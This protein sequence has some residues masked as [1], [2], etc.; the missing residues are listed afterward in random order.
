MDTNRDDLGF[1]VTIAFA[2]GEGD[3][4]R[5]FRT[6]GGL[7]DALAELDRHLIAPISTT[8]GA[9]LVLEDIERGSLKARL[10]AVVDDLPDDALKE[11]HVGRIVGHYLLK[12]K[13]SVLR[14]CADKNTIESRDDVK[15]LEAQLVQVALETDLR[16]IPAYAPLRSEILLGDVRNIQEA[17]THL[18]PADQA[19]YRSVDGATRFN[20]ELVL[21]D[22]VVRNVL[23]REVLSSEGERLVKVKKPDYLGQSMWVFKYEGH[24]IEAAIVD[25][26]WLTD[27]QSR[28]VVL[29]PGD[30]LKV[31]LNEQVHYG[32][33]NE[34]VHRHYEV[35][36]VIAVVPEQ[37]AQQNKLFRHN[38]L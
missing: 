13:H 33:D 38:D 9:R 21:S 6:M 1:E 19:E 16:R 8:L 22:D 5:V 15:A 27:F 29:Q 20:K 26:G 18:A 25:A 31:L 11:G 34:V 14:W 4:S 12:A 10:R 2:P 17:L 7:I 24:S 32:Y 30:S 3:P 23:T 35:V 37:S 36:R 28:R